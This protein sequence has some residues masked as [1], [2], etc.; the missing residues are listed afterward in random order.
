VKV[1]GE[2]EPVE[3]RLVESLWGVSVSVELFL[4][5]V[6]RRKRPETDEDTV[7]LDCTE[8]ARKEPLRWGAGKQVSHLGIE[9]RSDTHFGEDDWDLRWELGD[10]PEGPW[11]CQVARIG[12]G[13]AD[14]TRRR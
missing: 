10:S 4:R 5:P 1:F 2:F 12:S 8:G 9:S 11:S 14:D 6:A 13:G 3:S 7:P